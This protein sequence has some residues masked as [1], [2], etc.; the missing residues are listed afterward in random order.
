MGL[1]SKKKKAEIIDGVDQGIY[2][3]D[4]DAVKTIDDIKIIL[5]LNHRRVYSK[6]CRSIQ[7][8]NDVVK[9]GIDK[10]IFVKEN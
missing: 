2:K 10:K 8:F 3:I 1:F 6:N 4:Y 5:A 7:E 9:P